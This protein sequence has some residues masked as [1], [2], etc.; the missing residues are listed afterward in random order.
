MAGFCQLCRVLETV[1]L[2]ETG[3]GAVEEFLILELFAFNIVD[4]ILRLVAHQGVV[5]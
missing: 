2:V 1:T 5:S 3:Y 4:I